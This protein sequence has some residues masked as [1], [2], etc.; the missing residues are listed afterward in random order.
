MLRGE[1][2]GRRLPAEYAARL[3]LRRVARDEQGVGCRGALAVSRDQPAVIAAGR[4]ATAGEVLKRERALYHAGAGPYARTDDPDR[5]L[6]ERTERVA[7]VELDTWVE[8]QQ[9]Q[10]ED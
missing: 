3:W 4:L 5:L 7:A 10:H 6:A 1:A 9:G 2:S 8:S